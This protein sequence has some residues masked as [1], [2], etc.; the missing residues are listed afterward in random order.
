MRH[1][2]RRIRRVGEASLSALDRNDAGKV[3]KGFEK[4]E[5]AELALKEAVRRM[6]FVDAWAHAEIDRVVGDSES[7]GSVRDDQDKARRSVALELA[8]ARVIEDGAIELEHELG[9]LS[10]HFRAPPR[11][12]T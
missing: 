10:A 5:I 6:P 11:S 3:S 4:L 12:R 9:K 1:A 7:L 8:I 2:A